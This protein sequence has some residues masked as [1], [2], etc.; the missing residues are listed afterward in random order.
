MGNYG[1]YFLKLLLPSLFGLSVAAVHFTGLRGPSTSL[2][3]IEFVLASIA[4]VIIF[5][6][7]IL[8]KKSVEFVFLAPIIYLVCITLPMTFVNLFLELPGIRWQTTF[9]LI[10][11]SYVAL[12]FAYLK[13]YELEY[14]GNG[15]AA[16]IIFSFTTSLITGDIFNQFIRYAFLADN[17]NQLAVYSIC[18]AFLVSYLITNKI[19]KNIAVSIC[20][21]YGLLSVSDSLYLS[22]FI[23][24]S[25]Y[26]IMR[27]FTKGYIILMLSILL[28]LG[29]IAIVINFQ[30]TEFIS[31][32]IDLW[33]SADEGGARI[34]LIINGLI[35]FLDSPII[36]HGGG[37]FSGAYNPYMRFEAHN[38]FVD[39]LTIAGPIFTLL[40]YSPFVLAVKI[41]FQERKF[42]ETS[43]LLGVLSYTLFHFVGRHPIIWII[44]AVTVKIFII[45]R[46]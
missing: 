30:E 13:K 16:L 3:P 15:I 9:A 7:Y 44:W 11:V 8:E 33:Y 4:T 42:L 32:F 17:P 39:F 20:I 38:T 21:L 14:F 27:I 1:D 35:A 12:S 34:N 36:G 41:L 45:R 29:L 22:I 6:N 28:M 23:S 40:F 25:S 46:R 31:F 37:A 2:G 43:L 18:S 5:R 19:F 24:F 10:F 26:L